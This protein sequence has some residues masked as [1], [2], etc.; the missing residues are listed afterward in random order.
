MPRPWREVLGWTEEDER[1]CGDHGLANALVRRTALSERY[2]VLVQ[3]WESRMHAETQM[4]L[5]Q[6]RVALREALKEH[7]NLKRWK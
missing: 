6:L 4:G 1:K 5:E 7:E 2:D 3:E